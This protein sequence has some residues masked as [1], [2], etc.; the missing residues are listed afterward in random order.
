MEVVSV[1]TLNLKLLSEWTFSF[2]INRKKRLKQISLQ[3][4]LK[5]GKS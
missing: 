3:S 4:E 5:M 2:D 1:E